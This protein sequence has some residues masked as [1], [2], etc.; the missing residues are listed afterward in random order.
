MEIFLV[1]VYL[2]L[3]STVPIDQAVNQKL[4]RHIAGHYLKLPEALGIIWY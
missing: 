2:Q 4:L 3:D 1:Y